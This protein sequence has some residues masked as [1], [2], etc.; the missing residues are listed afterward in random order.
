MCRVPIPQRVGRVHPVGTQHELLERSHHRV[1]GHCDECTPRP[2]S[3]G[4]DDLR[5]RPARGPWTQLERQREWRPSVSG[6]YGF[7]IVGRERV[8]ERDRDWLLCVRRSGTLI[9]GDCALAVPSLQ[10]M[11]RYA[12]TSD[13]CEM[14]HIQRCNAQGMSVGA[15]RAA[16]ACGL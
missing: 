16:R 13:I 1:L 2:R 10:E 3:R 14:I 15:M 11:H 9:S 5:R 4:R 6:V 7:G 8:S 12:M